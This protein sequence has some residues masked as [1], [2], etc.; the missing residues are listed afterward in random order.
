M[1]EVVILDVDN[2]ILKGFSQELLVGYLR[3]KGYVSFLYRIILGLWLISYKLGFVK[4]PKS[5]MEYGF[6]FIKNKTVREMDTLV[7]DFFNT[8]W[9]KTIYP[10]MEKIIKEHQNLGRELILVSNAPD[11]LVKKLASYLKIN[12]YIATEL[13]IKDGIYTGK[14]N[15]EIM[16]G[17]RKLNAVNEYIKSN[18]LSLKNSWGYGDHTSDI[19]ILSEVAHPVAV[20]PSRGLRNLAIKNN[21]SILNI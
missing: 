2:T 19:F 8:V 15:G 6:A 13:E 1:K 20:N 9:L 11:I 18:G 3:K 4:D 16:Y 5:A 12:T 10:E 14:I 21:W 17:K 7:E